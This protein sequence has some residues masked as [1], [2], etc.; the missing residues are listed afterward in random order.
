MNPTRL[1]LPPLVLACLAVFAGAQSQLTP[2]AHGLTGYTQLTDIAYGNGAF[3]VLQSTSDSLASIDAGLRIAT[4][5]NG[6][7][8][9]ARTLTT[10]ATVNPN[11]LTFFNGRFILFGPS[12]SP[13]LSVI[14]TSTDGTTWT[15]T[16]NSD[17]RNVVSWANDGT[18][19]VAA[20]NDNFL[21]SSTDGQSFAKRTAATGLS[22]YLT[23]AHGQSKWFLTT[24]GA[25]TV[26][27]ST[28]GTGWTADTSALGS[29]LGGSRVY[30]NPATDSWLAYNQSNFFTST[31]GATFT[32]RGGSGQNPGVFIPV[33]TTD[34]FVG[35]SQFL[36]A[37]RTPIYEGPGIYASTTGATWHR[38]AAAAPSLL[39]S[40]GIFTGWLSPNVYSLIS[41]NGKYY[42]VG[43]NNGQALIASV[44]A[45]APAIPPVIAAQPQP[46][47]VATGSTAVLEVTATGATGYQW[48]RNGI[49][50]AGATGASLV[51]TNLQAGNAGAYTVD[52]TNSAGTTTSTAAT[53]TLGRAPN[54]LANLSVRAAMAAGQ[55]LIAGFVVDGGAKPVL[56]RA[57]GPALD[58][59]GLAGVGDPA[60]TLYNGGSVVGAN[61]NWDS[62][63]AATFASLGAF[64]F[65]PASKDAALQQSIDGAHTAQAT[66]TGTGS[67]LVE[68][69]DAGPDDGRE[70]VNLSTR[71]HVGTNDNILIAGFVLNGTGNRQLLIRAIG[72]SLTRFGV[73]G[74]L[75]DPRLTIYDG[76][77]AIATN[78]NWSATL[79]PVFSVVGAF[80][81][82]N[83]G[84]DAALVVTLEAGKGYT[85]QVSGV[86]ATTGEALVEIY[87]IP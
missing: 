20:G 70:L 46:L 44:D 54:F 42:M 57:A 39:I 26:Y 43:D 12:I 35:N 63:L 34:A 27:T 45:P 66:A 48:K 49:A 59:F 84:N 7:D 76:S 2:I 51:L 77:A 37:L 11:R 25:G 80:E 83:A 31:D 33:G 19:L 69:Y 68:A 36:M 71:F 85:V 73:T 5:A 10:S 65:D 15:S 67:I 50:V 24:N 87:A 47:T 52:A 74:A 28:N 86:G 79:A 56:I 61:D 41:A 14:W 1:L 23:A 58:R 38:V 82:V 16:T 17:L 81:L 3:V 40:S 62:A 75:A 8:W 22:S 30:F 78:D 72:P 9:I 4:S 60:V 18:T 13:E 21:L 6:T 53:L 32:N 64:T 29:T 55:T